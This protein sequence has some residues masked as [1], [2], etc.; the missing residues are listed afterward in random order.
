MLWR[1]S[2]SWQTS[3]HRARWK[4][5]R[6]DFI[7]KVARSGIARPSPLCVTTVR[8]SPPLAHALTVS[9]RY[10]SGHPRKSPAV[11]RVSL[12]SNHPHPG[13]MIIASG[14]ARW[15]PTVR[16]LGPRRE[17]QSQRYESIKARHSPSWISRLLISQNR[18]LQQSNLFY[19][20]LGH[21]RPRLWP[22]GTLWMVLSSRNHLSD[23]QFAQQVNL[24][25]W[26]SCHI[27]TIVAYSPQS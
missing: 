27:L 18:S 14:A 2:K 5:H 4:R 3:L 7:C 19:P 15:S 21:L 10:M 6:I 9:P 1:S 13:N 26:R 24:L 20:F 23:G 8:R 17:G 22:T 12:I 11:R 16:A 25:P